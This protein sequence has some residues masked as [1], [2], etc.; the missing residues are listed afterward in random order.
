MILEL[1]ASCL[2]ELTNNQTASL[3]IDMAL[4]EFATNSNAFKC[5]SS[6]SNSTQPDPTLVQRLHDRG[7]SWNAA[8]RACVMTNNRG[9]SDALGWAVAHFQDEDFDSPLFSLNNENGSCRYQG[10]LISLVKDTLQSIKARYESGKPGEKPVISKPKMPPLP[11]TQPAPVKDVSGNS[12]SLSRPVHMP[13]INE[14]DLHQKTPTPLD[15]QKDTSIMSPLHNNP[16]IETP[17]NASTKGNGGAMPNSADSMSSVDG[18]LGSRASMKRQISRGR[19]VL[20]TQK[21][22]ADERKRLAAEGKR[23]LEAARMRNKGV[24]AP[25]TSIVTKSIPDN[26]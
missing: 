21:F 3:V 22:S 20:G 13:P 4:E 14:S 17:T 8:R 26:D 9:Y 16:F 7:Y 15:L 12:V 5:T 23:L 10:E 11:P 19:E 25:P 18:S 24:V 6:A 2:A 1:A